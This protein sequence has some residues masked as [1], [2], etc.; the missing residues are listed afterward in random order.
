MRAELASTV[1]TL[2]L[3]MAGKSA[4]E[5]LP[6]GFVDWLRSIEPAHHLYAKARAALA[7]IEDA[8]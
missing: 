7:E 4:G 8:D 2:A 3:T 6:D 5:R 1:T